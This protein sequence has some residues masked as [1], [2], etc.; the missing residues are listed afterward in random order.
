MTKPSF[1]FFQLQIPGPLRLLRGWWPQQMEIASVT[2]EQQEAA[3]AVASIEKE[4]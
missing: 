1:H 3:A 4:A 2:E